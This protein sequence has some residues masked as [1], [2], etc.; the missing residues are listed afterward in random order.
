M[1]V[2]TLSVLFAVFLLGGCAAKVVPSPPPPSPTE[3]TPSPEALEAERLGRE[4][5]QSRGELDE[6]RA[7][8]ARVRDQ[9]QSARRQAA[10]AEARY[11]ALRR[12]MD[13]AL[14][15][16]LA[17]KASLRG[18]HNRALAIS[19]IAEVRVQL[20][21]AARRNEH[22]VA[23][24]LRRAEELLTRADR[25]LGEGNY[26]G[27]SYLAD[28]AGELVGHARAVAEVTVPPVRDTSGGVIPIVPAR[29]VEVLEAANLRHGPGSAERRLGVAL[30]GTRLTAVGRMGE[31]FEVDTE[32]GQRVWIHRT[33]VR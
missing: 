33:L 15:E 7:E 10:A 18:V 23:E 24:R 4:L 20:Q 11:Q 14:E 32:A 5:E 17:S 21:E 8:G 1:G 12:E 3:P 26:G 30:P 31:W 22:G 16:V 6:S 9:L 28:R 29:S 27:A 19:R 2:R 25:A 13:R